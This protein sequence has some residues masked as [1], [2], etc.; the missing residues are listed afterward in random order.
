MLRVNTVAF[1]FFLALSLHAQQQAPQ[2][3]SALVIQGL[4]QGQV[5]L[6]GF[7][8]FHTGTTPAGRLRHGTILPGNL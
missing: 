5:K 7:W 3:Q 1:I 4:G 6:N 2:P 8:L